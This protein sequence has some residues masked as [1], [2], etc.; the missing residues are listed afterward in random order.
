ME[1]SKWHIIY[2]F[3]TLYLVA[4]RGFVVYTRLKNKCLLIGKYN[5]YFVLQLLYSG[6]AV[7]TQPSNG[8]ILHNMAQIMQRKKL[9]LYSGFWW[10]VYIKS[11]LIKKSAFT[12]VV[13]NATPSILTAQQIEMW[14]KYKSFQMEIPS[15]GTRLILCFSQQRN[16]KCSQ[17]K[18][19]RTPKRRAPCI[20]PIKF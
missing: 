7:L 9:M 20:L 14:K 18:I 13:R 2:F 5:G 17:E 10:F 4:R 19:R 12:G 3:P 1:N 15:S 11:S 6:V 16:L 8:F